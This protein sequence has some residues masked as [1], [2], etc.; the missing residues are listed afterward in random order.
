MHRQHTHLLYQ[1]PWTPLQRLQYFSF[2]A[3]M[4]GTLTAKACGT[5]GFGATVTVLAEASVE[6]GKPTP[7][8]CGT[9]A[10]PAM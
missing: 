7:L 1:P 2:A 9:C 10:K 5:G 4:N 8:G 3:P 6:G